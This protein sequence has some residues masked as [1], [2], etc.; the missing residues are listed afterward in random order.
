MKIR[1]QVS[2]YCVV[3]KSITLSELPKLQ[4]FFLVLHLCKQTLQ[5]R[6]FR[7]AVIKMMQISVFLNMAVLICCTAVDAYASSVR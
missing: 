1:L 4:Y 2:R 6:L 5:S 7:E 3:L